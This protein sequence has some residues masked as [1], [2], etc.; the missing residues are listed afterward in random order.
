VLFV[1]PS[2]ILN[3]WDWPDAITFTCLGESPSDDAVH[4][5]LA[6]KLDNTDVDWVIIDGYR[7]R[8]DSWQVQINEAQ[9]RLLMLDDIADQAFSA[10]AV[11][12][13]N[14]TDPDFYA[15]RGINADHC[16][17]GTQYALIEPE[18]I[19]P[20]DKLINADLARVL[21]VFGGADRRQLTSKSVAVLLE[22]KPSLQL[23][24]VLGPYSSWV[25]PPN[26]QSR[27]VFHKAPAG[28]AELLRHADL[29]V[30]AAGST[31]WQAC[32]MGC[33]SVAVQTVDNQAQIVATLQTSQA[34]LIA[35]A[36]RLDT[37]LRY[38]VEV[39]RPMEVRKVLV[40]R[41]RDLVDGAG[42]SRVL[43]ALYSAVNRTGKR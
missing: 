16:L 10:D 19:A 17:L 38:A 24:V 8:G 12:N 9:A 20:G 41:A 15:T 23:D 35:D 34:A 36:N 11:L 42:A 14:G 27:V 6:H 40:Q 31:A 26:D 22:L 39:L 33:P 3:R 37:E 7:F 21:V 29:V 32:A 13:Q 25:D 18:Y 30:T 2:T 4:A 5:I 1:G 43:E 28:I